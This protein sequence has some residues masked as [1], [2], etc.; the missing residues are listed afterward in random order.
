LFSLTDVTSAPIL[1]SSQIYLD[2]K[3]DLFCFDEKRTISPVPSHSLACCCYPPPLPCLPPP[4]S[5]ASPPV[6]L[7]SDRPSFRPSA[8]LSV[9]RSVISPFVRPFPVL[10]HPS[11]FIHPSSFSRLSSPSLPATTTTTHHHHRHHSGPATIS[12]ISSATT[13]TCPR[14]RTANFPSFLLQTTPRRNS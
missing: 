7:P 13:T 12:A 2:S 11:F 8:R 10:L 3:F 5:L 4:F 14:P 9:R 1:Y 6:R